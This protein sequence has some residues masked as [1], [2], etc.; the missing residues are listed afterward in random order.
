MTNTLIA[1]TFWKHKY[2]KV[3][4]NNAAWEVANMH[5]GV[6]RMPAEESIQEARDLME[7]TILP[8]KHQELEEELRP[9]SA[10]FSMIT[11]PR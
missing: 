1:A 7:E 5:D 4:I 8:Q 2:V 11:K 6:T 3:T 9:M 10:S